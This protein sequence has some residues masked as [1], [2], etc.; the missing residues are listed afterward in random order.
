M[1]FTESPRAQV[2]VTQAVFQ[3]SAIPNYCL[4]IFFYWLIHPPFS[5]NSP[6]SPARGWGPLQ[7]S[8]IPAQLAHISLAWGR[9]MTL[10][11]ITNEPDGSRATCAILPAL[12]KVLFCCFQCPLLCAIFST[13]L[14]VSVGSQHFSAASTAMSKIPSLLFP[15][16]TPYHLHCSEILLIPLLCSQIMFCRA[17]D[18]FFSPRCFSKSLC[19]S[20]CLAAS[21]LVG[22]FSSQVSILF[23]WHWD[24]MNG[25]G[26]KSSLRL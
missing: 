20:G 25:S 9:E 14:F 12:L 10:L 15:I 6:T 23:L 8:K 22:T 13:L 16:E 7:L 11:C 3:H 17:L 26:I 4:S 2:F 1:K 24:C 5:N 19:S 21:P 18:C